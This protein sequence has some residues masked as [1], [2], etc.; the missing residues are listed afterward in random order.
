MP[1]RLTFAGL[2]RQPFAQGLF[3]LLRRLGGS[4]EL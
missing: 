2:L 4:L 3:G 1:K